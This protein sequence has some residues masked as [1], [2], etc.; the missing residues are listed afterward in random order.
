MKRIEAPSLSWML[1]GLAILAALLDMIPSI[2][3][4]L[5]LKDVSMATVLPGW[6]GASLT[7]DLSLVAIALV[8]GHAMLE[9]RRG[10]ALRSFALFLFGF[11][12]IFMI[13]G[14]VIGTAWSYATTMLV[15]RYASSSYSMGQPLRVVFGFTGWLSTLLV[16]WLSLRLVLW[17]TLAPGVPRE[18]MPVPRWR[19]QA[20]LVA[21][22]VFLALWGMLIMAAFTLQ[23]Q[24]MAV[25]FAGG[26]V[27]GATVLYGGLVWLFAWLGARS[28]YGSVR[29]FRLLLVGFLAWLAMLAPAL[30]TAVVVPWVRYTSASEGPVIAAA[31]LLGALSMALPLI[32]VWGGMRM[33]WRSTVA[34]PPLPI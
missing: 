5:R 11:F 4:L 8:V 26:A 34:P 27:A 6:I 13:L 25:T 18:P 2:F 24:V 29:P 12:L 10:E 33:T 14:L 9:P 20:S 30:V 23:A 32:V 17:M 15:Y 28:Q 3:T 7:H 19:M 16:F 22:F 31:L 21:T 1:A